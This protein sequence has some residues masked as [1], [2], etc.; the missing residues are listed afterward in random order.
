MAQKRSSEHLSGVWTTELSGLGDNRGSLI[1]K[2][3]KE[4]KNE[5][6]DF[7]KSEHERKRPKCSSKNAVMARMNRLKK[8]SF[9]ESLQS[10]VARLSDENIKLKQTLE[11]QS[12]L[13][14]S[15]RKEVHYLKGVLANN[16]EISMLLKS[17]QNTGLPVTSSLSKHTLSNQIHSTPYHNY[18]R[19]RSDSSI[20][21]SF[22]DLVDGNS[23]TLTLDE[24][25]QI[26]ITN[27]VALSLS[28]PHDNVLDLPLLSPS[29]RNLYD[30]EFS[31]CYSVQPTTLDSPVIGSAADDEPF[32][33][34]GVCLHVAKRRVS[35][36]FCSTCSSNAYSTWD[37]LD[38]VK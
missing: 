25:E 16:K 32:M 5:K 30:T 27:D 10:D 38:I 14:C 13:V 22:S 4:C 29:D 9:M 36:E 31:G 37:D 11:G 18:V 28:M 6:F 20:S 24:K 33:D 26:P 3:E 1:V 2:A 17:I 12:S 8:K 7:K 35:L 21:S 34:V 23:A 19:K 15:L